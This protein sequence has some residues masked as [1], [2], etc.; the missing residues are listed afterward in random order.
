MVQ[1]FRKCGPTL[2]LFSHMFLLNFSRYS[3]FTNF[4]TSLHEIL[5]INFNLSL[6]YWS[7]ICLDNPSRRGA[8]LPSPGIA[9]SV[10]HSVEF[11][12]LVTYVWSVDKKLTEMWWHGLCF[13][14]KSSNF[15]V[16]SVRLLVPVHRGHYSVLVAMYLMFQPYTGQRNFTG[17][18][19]TFSFQYLSLCQRRDMTAIVFPA[20][21]GGI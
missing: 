8:L 20:P 10:S 12:V 18:K 3:L 4:N 2:N 6:F 14:K 15:H 5:L 1:L 13:V 17:T 19:H 7:V 9:S 11:V 21:L 16:L